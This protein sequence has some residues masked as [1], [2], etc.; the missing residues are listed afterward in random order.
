[1][2]KIHLL[3]RFRPRKPAEPEVQRQQWH[4][5]C[6]H[7]VPEKEETLIVTY[8]PKYKAY[9]RR[10]RN[11]QISRAQKIIDGN[12]KIRK[13]KNENDP[14]RFV[15]KTSLTKDG[16]IAEKHVYELDEDRI[17]DEEQYDGFYAVVTNLEDDPMKTK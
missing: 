11:E 10:I 16:E 6:H 13:G 4:G 7:A 5:L 15:M 9:Q 1:M 3:L 14:Y 2:F 8:S 17:Q 12:G